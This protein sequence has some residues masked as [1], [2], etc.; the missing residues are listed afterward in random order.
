[1]AQKAAL[2]HVALHVTDFQRSA[3]FYKDVILLDTIQEPFHDGNHAWFSIGGNMQLH[4]IGRAE[5]KPH[6]SKRV[7][8]CFT[9]ASLDG[10]IDRLARAG[11]FFEDL[12]GK[13]GG[14]T[15]RP[16][17]VHQIYFQDPDGYWIEANDAAGK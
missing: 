3:T 6:L 1:M 10:I 7:H 11:F 5:Q 13:K 8:L 2:D 12:Q 17:G 4:L 15:T 14:L 16:D 9:Y